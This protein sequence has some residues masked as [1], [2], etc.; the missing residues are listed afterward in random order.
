M[1]AKT[2]Y[3]TDPQEELRGLPIT[4]FLTGACL[5]TDYVRSTTATV[6]L[7]INEERKVRLFVLLLKVV[8]FFSVSFWGEFCFPGPILTDTVCM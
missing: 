2:T 5:Y 6:T 4:T 7:T 8:L 3:I 1:Y